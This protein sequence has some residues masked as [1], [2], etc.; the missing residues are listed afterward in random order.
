MESLTMH[1]SGPMCE[2]SMDL[3]GMESWISSLRVSPVSPSQRQEAVREIVTNATSGLKRRELLA[4]FDPVSCSW[5]MFSDS[6]SGME[7][8]KHTLTRSLRSLPR[9]VTWDTQGLYRLETPEPHIKGTGSGS[10]PTPQVLDLPNKKANIKKW[11]GLN[12]L[13][14]MAEE[15]MTPT[16]AL[17]GVKTQIDGTYKPGLKTQASQWSTPTSDVHTHSKKYAQGGTPLSLQAPRTPMPGQES[18]SDT[19]TS[20]QPP[21]R[22][23][24]HFVTWLMGFPRGWLCSRPLEMRLFPNRQRS[25]SGE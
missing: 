21:R 4:R 22:L 11:D 19:Q 6:F 20:P 25:F 7:M 12:S 17:E 10:W 5:K 13:T 9:W 15:W 23:N 16:V 2:R 8:S 24:P 14:A 1:Q 3:A 18:S